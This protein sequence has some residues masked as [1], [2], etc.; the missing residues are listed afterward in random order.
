M[1]HHVKLALNDHLIREAADVHREK[2]V[3]IVPRED[4]QEA[5]TEG[6]RIGMIDVGPGPLRRL[7]EGGTLRGLGHRHQGIE[8]TTA[9]T[10]ETPDADHAREA[11]HLLR[12]VD[13]ETAR[14]TKWPNHPSRR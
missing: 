13:D 11:D 2:K 4:A 6:T 10:E 12:L 14:N 8:G 3:I 7:I 1:A 5:E 9:T